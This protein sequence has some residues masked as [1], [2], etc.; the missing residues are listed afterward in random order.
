M[1]DYNVFRKTLPRH[2][3]IRNYVRCTKNR[4]RAVKRASIEQRD[5]NDLTLLSSLKD[6]ENNTY[7]TTLVIVNQIGNIEEMR[8]RDDGAHVLKRVVE[9]TDTTREKVELTL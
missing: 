2:S 3:Q 1:D 8:R 9:P 7:C 6:L 5:A 4:I